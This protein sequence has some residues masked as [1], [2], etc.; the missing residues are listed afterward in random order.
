MK[1]QTP[2]EFLTFNNGLC[3]IYTVKANQRDEKLL[4][5]CFGDR[6]IGFKRHYAARAA[7][8]EITR[9]IQVPLQTSIDAIHRI[10]I[11]GEEYKIEQVQQLRDTNPPATVL[12]LRRVK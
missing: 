11:N 10:V 2:T 3:D 8:S 9:L 12:T 5:L 6:T 1:I 7:N 4:P